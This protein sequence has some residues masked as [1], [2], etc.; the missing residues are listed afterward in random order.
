MCGQFQSLQNY[1]YFGKQTITPRATGAGFLRLHQEPQIVRFEKKRFRQAWRP[2]AVP[3]RNPALFDKTRSLVEKAALG[4]N[5][6]GGAGEWP[7][8]E[9]SFCLFER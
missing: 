2:S 1:N 8:R 4:Q 9:R 7:E 6:D 3:Q 5:D